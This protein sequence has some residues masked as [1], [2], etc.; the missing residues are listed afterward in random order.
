MDRFILVYG[1]SMLP[2]VFDGPVGNGAARYRAGR[3]FR[4]FAVF[5]Q[6]PAQSYIV[7]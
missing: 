6:K 1:S 7:I 3:L 5:G 4:R 2:T